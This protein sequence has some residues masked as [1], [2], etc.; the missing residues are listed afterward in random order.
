MSNQTS[1]QTNSHQKCMNL[2]ANQGDK[3]KFIAPKH[4][5]DDYFY[6][7]ENAEKLLKQGEIYTVKLTHE[8]DPFVFVELEEFPG[9][10]FYA[11]DFVDC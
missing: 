5:H 1:N 7:G 9:N 6:A 10:L 2:Y 8:Y 11:T 4:D 3:V